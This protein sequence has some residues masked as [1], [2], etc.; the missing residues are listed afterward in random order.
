M[1]K[2]TVKSNNKR[3]ANKT[4]DNIK[5]IR[6]VIPLISEYYDEG[7]LVNEKPLV[8]KLAKLLKPNQWL[9]LDKEPREY[10]TKMYWKQSTAFP[11]PSGIWA[12]KGEW[13]MSENKYLTLLEVDYSR[14]LVLV[15]KEDY[16]AFEKNYC[17]LQKLSRITKINFSAT[18]YN[19][20]KKNICQTS[21]NWAKV[22]I[23]YDG[24]VMIPNPKPY[25]P[26]DRNNLESRYNH[27]W[28]ESYGVSSLFVWNQNINTPIT[29][30]KSLGKIQDIHDKAKKDKK[31]FET[32][33]LETVKQG[34]E[35]ISFNHIKN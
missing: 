7:S 5:K 10:N 17:K 31:T 16:I 28:L 6:K 33:L 25:F 20:N 1:S 2:R 4:I 22:A 8:E 12:T 3:I 29:K 11:T 35:Q 23:D 14:L 26:I 18:K 24:I 21:I 13:R 9:K 30:Y 19:N 15:T 32:T 27:I 34:I